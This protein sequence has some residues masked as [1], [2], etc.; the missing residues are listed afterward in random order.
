MADKKPE[1]KAYGAQQGRDLQRNWLSDKLTSLFDGEEA[2]EYDQGV[3]ATNARAQL[4]YRTSNPDARA[5][6]L[7][8]SPEG[9]AERRGTG[10]QKGQVRS[11]VRAPQGVKA[12]NAPEGAAEEPKT[13]TSAYGA[14]Y[15]PWK[16]GSEPPAGTEAPPEPA[17]KVI[18]EPPMDA[19][20][21][22]TVGIYGAEGDDYLYEVHP[23]EG[24]RYRKQGTHEWLS[25]EGHPDAKQA[26]LDQIQSGQMDLKVDMSDIADMPLAQQQR[27]R[28]ARYGMN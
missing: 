26:I 7:D 22:P 3:D 14:D 27:T 8:Y 11:A 15:S 5:D 16:H 24:V 21:S 19:D 17:G 6:D 10:A 1:T 4:R 20:L 18:A 9:L 28:G 23:T 25:A 12:D 2:P 13:E